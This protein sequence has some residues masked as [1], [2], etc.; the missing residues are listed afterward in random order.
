M[1]ILQKSEKPVLLNQ[2]E[3]NR[4]CRVSRSSLLHKALGAS[5]SSLLHKALGVSQFNLLYEA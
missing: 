1:H 2:Q 4:H 3:L 5:W